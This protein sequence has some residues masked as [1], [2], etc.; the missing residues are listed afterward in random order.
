VL[1][2]KDWQQLCELAPG[3]T[4][5]SNSAIATTTSRKHVAQIA[6]GGFHIEL[7]DRV[8]RCMMMVTDETRQK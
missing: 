1:C 7:G 8:N 4:T 2:S 3:R 5:S 6:E